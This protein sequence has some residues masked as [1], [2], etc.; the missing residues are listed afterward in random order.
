MNLP[1]ATG[2]DGGGDNGGKG[3]VPRSARDS[4]DGRMRDLSVPALCRRMATRM[5]K[6]MGQAVSSRCS[7]APV[8]RKSVASGVALAPLKSK[9]IWRAAGIALSDIFCV[10]SANERVSVCSC[11]AMARIAAHQ[12]KCEPRAARLFRWGSHTLKSR[13]RPTAETCKW[14][15]CYFILAALTSVRKCQVTKQ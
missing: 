14:L 12:P 6:S 2:S 8:R 1:V 15:N 10:E 5:G 3:V 7:S 4:Q 9:A 13:G 11:E